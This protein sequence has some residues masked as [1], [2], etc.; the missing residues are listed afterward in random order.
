M[1]VQT[2]FSSFFF[3]SNSDWP[4]PPGLDVLSISGIN[5][6]DDNVD[7]RWF[8]SPATA[9]WLFS[10]LIA[11]FMYRASCD[12]VDMRQRYFRHTSQLSGRS[13]LLHNL[14]H[15]VR[16]DD[17]LKKWVQGMTHAV[18]YPIQD[19]IIGHDSQKLTKLTQEHEAAVKRLEDTLSSYLQ[20][21]SN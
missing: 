17:Q 3:F 1:V 16:S 15:E 10:I 19:A 9:T 5:Y 14:P 6:T 18:P 20:G 12:Y 4:P 7:T 21:M 13:L 8:W 2:L 11:Y